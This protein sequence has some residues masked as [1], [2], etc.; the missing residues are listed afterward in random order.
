V[1]Q[2]PHTYEYRYYKAPKSTEAGEY[3][4]NASDEGRAKFLLEL[5]RATL[6]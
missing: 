3:D 4:C 5:P 2:Q 1:F 6:K